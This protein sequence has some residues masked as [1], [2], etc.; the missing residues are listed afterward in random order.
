[1]PF[2]LKV[3]PANE[4]HIKRLVG[5]RPFWIC[6]D[7]HVKRV[8]DDLRIFKLHRGIVLQ[9][10]LIFFRN[11]KHSC[12]VFVPPSVLVYLL[13]GDEKETTGALHIDA[14]RDSHFNALVGDL[15]AI[16]MV[17]QRNQNRVRS[18]GIQPLFRF[19]FLRK[20][21]LHRFEFTFQETLLG[22]LG[23]LTSPDRAASLFKLLQLMSFIRPPLV[24]DRDFV[25]LVLESFGCKLPE[26]FATTP[27]HTV[28]AR[29][30]SEFHNRVQDKI[31]ASATILSVFHR[32]ITDK[33]YQSRALSSIGQSK[34]ATLSRLFLK[35]FLL[36]RQ[37]CGQTLCPIVIHF[38]SCLD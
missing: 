38:V 25:I 21:R 33:A 9:L 22:G 27:R 11:K 4:C 37:L 6:I 20:K 19:H 10:Q 8:G 1:M 12:R 5:R 15:H 28:H 18:L 16:G 2:G 7:R 35:C 34:L 23:L 31:Q 24:V 3:N 26:H 29:I 14:V 17:T 36:Q 30:K 13:P 32:I